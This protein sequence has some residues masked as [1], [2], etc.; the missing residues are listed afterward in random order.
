MKLPRDVSGPDLVRIL[1]E[2]RLGYRR[3]HQRGSHVI[4]ETD[5]PQQH[6][7][8]IPAHAALRLGTL[9]AIVSAVSRA[10]GIPKDDIIALL[11]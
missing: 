6:R 4:V 7:I 1:C 3:V 5:D 2:P 8:A 11:H 9:N 10:K